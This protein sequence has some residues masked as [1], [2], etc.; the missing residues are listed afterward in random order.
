MR[1]VYYDLP[2]EDKHS[3][4]DDRLENAVQAVVFCE[5]K[6]NSRQDAPGN[7]NKQQ[8]MSN[9]QQTVRLLTRSVVF[10]WGEGIIF[11]S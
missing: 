1:F 9:R 5:Y 11:R 4:P 2:A 10:G 7:G 8:A 6:E 3:Q